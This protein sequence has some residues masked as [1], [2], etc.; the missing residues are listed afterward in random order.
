MILEEF[1]RVRDKKLEKALYKLNKKR[2]D[3][4]DDGGYP[5]PECKCPYGDIDPKDCEELC[6]LNYL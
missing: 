5:A 3:C 2:A 4:K 1:V 6:R